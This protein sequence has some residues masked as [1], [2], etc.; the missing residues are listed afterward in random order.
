MRIKRDC[1]RGILE[2]SQEE[3]IHKVLQCF[4]IQGGKALSIPMVLYIKRDCQREIGQIHTSSHGLQMLQ[5]E[6]GRYT[7]TPPEERICQLCE[8]E[9]ETKEHYICRCLVYDEIRGRY[10]CLVRE[11]FG[12]VAR[13][14]NYEDQ[15]CLG[16]FLEELC[17]TN[18]CYHKRRKKKSHTQEPIHGPMLVL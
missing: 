3:Y 10:L 13:V 18:K 1:Q 7:S 9:P 2:L 11:D 15:R 16:L 12:P 17:K 4:N 6:T 5:L 8:L 14:M